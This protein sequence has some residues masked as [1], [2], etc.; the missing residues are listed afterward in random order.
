MRGVS[1][2]R[3]QARQDLASLRDACYNKVAGTL[4]TNGIPATPIKLSWEKVGGF[5]RW[6][7]RKSQDARRAIIAA[8]PIVFQL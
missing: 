2:A 4:L 1:R 3:E 5:P 7:M 8:S 6:L